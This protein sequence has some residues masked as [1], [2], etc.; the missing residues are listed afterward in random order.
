MAVY[1]RRPKNDDDLNAVLQIAR[2][3]DGLLADAETDPRN[4]EMWV[5]ET[6]DDRVSMTRLEEKRAYL[7]LTIGA[8][9]FILGDEVGGSPA[10][11]RRRRSRP[12]RRWGYRDWSSKTARRS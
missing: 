7:G 11:G 5:I 1:R 10:R 8:T 3:A 6:R 9:E 4:K 2:H 12:R